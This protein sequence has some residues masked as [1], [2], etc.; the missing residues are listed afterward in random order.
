M[1]YDVTQVGFVAPPE[2]PELLGIRFESAS[3]NA[4]QVGLHAAREAAQHRV[5]LC[6]S[7]DHGS[8]FAA[9][10]EDVAAPFDARQLRLPETR[11]R[12]FKYEGNET[13]RFHA[14]EC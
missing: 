3:P 4:Q 1:V 9:A 14:A 8:I 12:C 6:R 11:E 5:I 7:R 10:T 13:N 2:D